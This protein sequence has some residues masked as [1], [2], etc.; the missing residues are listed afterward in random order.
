[1][2][3]LMARTLGRMATWGWREGG[4]RGR[5]ERE[6]GR[7]RRG[8]KRERERERERER[9]GGGV[10]VNNYPVLHVHMYT[11]S[12]TATQLHVYTLK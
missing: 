5:R 3:E 1:M 8:R 7:E 10:T 9:D 12:E 11:T 2:S 4:E 6:R